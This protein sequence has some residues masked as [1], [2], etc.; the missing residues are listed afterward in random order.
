MVASH[1]TI[2]A[3][4]P[5]GLGEVVLADAGHPHP[6][7]PQDGQRGEDE[8]HV[9]LGDRLRLTVALHPRIQEQ[10]AERADGGEHVEQPE[11]LVGGGDGQ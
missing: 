3:G 7:D 8:P 2:A 10:R 4:D 11:D 6:E 5:L 1:T 9:H